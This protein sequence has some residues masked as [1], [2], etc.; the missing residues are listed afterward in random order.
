[1]NGP[2]KDGNFSALLEYLK[3]TRGFDFSGYKPSSLKR[4]IQKRMQGVGIESYADYTDYLEVHPEEFGHHFNMILINVT[5]F[6]RDQPSWDYLAAEVLPRILERKQPG[7]PVRVWSAGTSS[8]EG[9]SAW[10][11]CWRRRS[12]SRPFENG[13]RSA[14][15]T[16]TRR[17]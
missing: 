10:P 12:A 15:R 8:S 5:A 6:F 3:R 16:W 13:S 4:R 14:P 11:W 17:R 7:E 2:E 1:M 9:R